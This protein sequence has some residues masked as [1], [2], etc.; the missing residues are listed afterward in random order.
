[1]AFNTNIDKENLVTLKSA[2]T[3]TKGNTHFKLNHFYRCIWLDKNT[4]LVY[5]EHFTKV[6]YNSLFETAQKRVLRDFKTLGILG[7]GNTPISKSLFTKLA[8]IHT[9]GSGRKSLKIWFFR[10]SR[11]IIYGFYPTQG[12]KAEAQ[13][14]CYS[15]YLEIIAGNM[16]CLDERDLCF[17]NCGIPIAYGELRVN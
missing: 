12:T 15:W 2:L 1:M 5:G 8:D 6:E 7:K 17:G 3:A 9:Y 11:D 14:E 13:N 10:D 4:A 16:A